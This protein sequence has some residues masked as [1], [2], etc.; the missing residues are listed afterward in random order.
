[1]NANFL[2]FLGTVAVVAVVLTS[3]A[4]ASVPAQRYS[5]PTQD[6]VYDT[7]TKL[8]WQRA[9]ASTTYDWAGAKTYCRDLSLNGQG[10]RVP[11]IKEMETIVDDSRLDPPAIDPEAFSTP[12]A[13]YLWC[14]SS[15]AK[16]TT[17]YAWVVDVSDGSSYTT[18]Q[19]EK[20]YVRCVR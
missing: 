12:L 17:V 18:Y 11:T 4:A 15:Q 13:G 6:T 8:T 5:H 19:S 14:S 2:H 3:S 7:K 20:Y 1:M 10:W 16:A 9:V